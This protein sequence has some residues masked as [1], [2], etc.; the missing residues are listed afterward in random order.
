MT[1]LDL[2][3]LAI[4]LVLVLAVVAAWIALGMLPGKI[5]RNRCHPQADAI[6]VCGWWGAI[7][8]GLLM[9]LAF[10]W[11]YTDP[12]WRERSAA[13][14]SGGYGGNQDKAVK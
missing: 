8:L 2:F 12:R 11:A 14:D 10:I 6:N 4:L 13:A 7:T 1:V 3:A 5:A 9:P